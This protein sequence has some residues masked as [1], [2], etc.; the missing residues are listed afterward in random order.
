MEWEQARK[1]L[2]VWVVRKK[3]EEN[4]YEV[5]MLFFA[6]F[7]NVCCRL[8]FSLVIAT[9]LMIC[10]WVLMKE[11][12]S[13]NTQSTQSIHLQYLLATIRR[14]QLI[15]L[16]IKYKLLLYYSR[17]RSLRKFESFMIMRCQCRNPNITWMD[18]NKLTYTTISF[19]NEN[20][21]IKVFL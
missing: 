18:H 1:Q 17:S 10:C 4:R 9:L 6:L 15:K 14:I 7:H 12:R 11:N 16:L 5:S 3:Y 13:K 21:H 8:I 20:F 19:L 2:E